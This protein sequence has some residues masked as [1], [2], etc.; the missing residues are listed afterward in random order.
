MTLCFNSV[1]SVGDP[2]IK[3]PFSIQEKYQVPAFLPGPKMLEAGADLAGGELSG[4]LA[5]PLLE[6]HI[7]KLKKIVNITC[8]A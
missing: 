4:W 2:I 1:G 5:T 7:T 6:K 3:A 8:M